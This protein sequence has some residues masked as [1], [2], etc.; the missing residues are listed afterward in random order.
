MNESATSMPQMHVQQIQYAVSGG[1]TLGLARR[2]KHLHIGLRIA[3]AKYADAVLRR[4]NRLFLTEK[5]AEKALLGF[6]FGFEVR[7]QIAHKVKPFRT[8]T[9]FDRESAALERHSHAPPLALKSFFAFDPT[10][11][12]GVFV[13]HQA[14]EPS[15]SLRQKW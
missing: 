4:L 2:I 7:I 9:I 6:G 5:L 3:L 10:F 1:R 12:G 14:F 15:Q 8:I 11:A 13:D